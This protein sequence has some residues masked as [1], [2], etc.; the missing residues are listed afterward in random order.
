MDIGNCHTNS[1]LNHNESMVNY[2]KPF[3]NFLIQLSNYETISKTMCT[4][5]ETM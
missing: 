5:N 2:G 3:V 1:K 4:T